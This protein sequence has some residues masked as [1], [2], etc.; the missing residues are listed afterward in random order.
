MNNRLR[1][2]IGE[3]EFEAEGDIELIER[4][5]DVFLNTLLPSAINSISQTRKY[6]QDSDIEDMN[7]V[8]IETKEELSSAL[9]EDLSRTSLSVFLK[10]YG[11]F[12]EQDFVL[13]AVYFDEIKNGNKVFT[14]ETI[15]RY[16]GEARRNEYSNISMLLGPL[17]KKGYIMDNP[18]SELANPKQY[19]LTNEGIEYVR[20]YVPKIEELGKPKKSSTRAKHLSK[21]E[22]Q[23]VN[24]NADDLKMDKYIDV[25]SLKKFIEQML[26]VMYIV[27]NEKKGLFFS[28]ADIQYI[29]T[30]ILGLPATTKQIRGV[31]ERNRKWF[32]AEKDPKNA[33]ANVYRLLDGG[34]KFAVGLLNN[35]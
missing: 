3:I 1:F 26:M 4:E 8:L 27:T 14:S 22:S 32:Y 28:V 17:A 7:M 2:K 24:L 29:L 15:K 18:D 9:K 34:K 31:L 20:N 35:K 11:N 19:I 33:K 25:C 6:K 23:Y 21:V 5:R 30:K 10:K 13:L 16:Y 12:S